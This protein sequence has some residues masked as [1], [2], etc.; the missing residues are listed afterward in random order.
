MEHRGDGSA[1]AHPGRTI[2]TETAL[3]AARPA[4]LRAGQVV[5]GRAASALVAVVLLAQGRRGAVAGCG[6]SCRR[7]QRLRRLARPR[8]K[9]PARARARP[10]V[11][12]GYE[13]TWY[14]LWRERRLPSNV[15]PFDARLDDPLERERLRR[16]FER[17]LDKPAGHVLPVQRAANGSGRWRSSRWLLRSERCYLLPGDS[18]MGLR[19]PLDSLPWAAPSERPVLHAPDPMQRFPDLP[20]RPQV[21]FQSKDRLRPGPPNRP[22]R[23]S[24]PRCAPSRARACSTSSCRPSRRSRIT[25]SSCRRWRPRR[26]ARHSGLARGLR[27]TQGCAPR[28]V[29][30]HPRSWRARGEY[31]PRGELARARRSHHLPVRAGAR[32]PPGNREVH[33]RRPPLRHRRRQP[34][35]S[36]GRAP[37]DSPFLRRPDLLASLIAYWHNHPSL[38]YLFSGLF[39]CPRIDEARNDSVYEIER[40][41]RAGRKTASQ[42][43]PSIASSGIC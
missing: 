9:L 4:P 2:K 16:V 35:R 26:R 31:P 20:S 3:R 42:C 32:M 40:S 29:P 38:S 33:A 13:D 24:A 7:G 30:H 43:G 41:R 34:L 21:Q 37:P 36:A 23:S 11:F 17:G 6:A 27:A 25:S 14:Y 12:T 15:D 19:L 22:R 28:V 1:Q 10:F 39:I 18:P 8:G 5:S